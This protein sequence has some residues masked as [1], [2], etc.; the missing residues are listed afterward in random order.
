MERPRAAKDLAVA[1]ASAILAWT[2]SSA[3][4]K[5]STHH[6]RLANDVSSNLAKP[7]ML[8][9]DVSINSIKF[10]ANPVA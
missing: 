8:Q 10:G 2:C 4:A 5:G 7:I 6:E 1:G 3:S 9:V